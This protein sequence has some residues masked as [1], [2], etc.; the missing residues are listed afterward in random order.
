MNWNIPKE[1]VVVKVTW[2]D[3][4]SEPTLDEMDLDRMIELAPYIS[5]GFKVR[6]TSKTLVIC[7]GFLPKQIP[8]DSTLFRNVLAI[9]KSQIRKVEIIG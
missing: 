4:W 8:N 9:P 6:E 5:V 1:Y 3:A 7:Q 2:S